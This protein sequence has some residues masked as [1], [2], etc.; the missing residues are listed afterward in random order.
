M[1]T[2]KEAS[3]TFV[4]VPAGT[5][6]ARAIQCLSLGT[7]TDQ[8]GQFLPSF[9]VLLAWE[10]P[11][12]VVIA[13]DKTERPMV[14]SKEYTLSLGKKSNLRRD[15]EGWRGR[16]F[17]KEEL[18]GFQVENVLD[19]PCMLNI[20]HKT[21]ASGNTYAV[22][23][24]ISPL[25]KGVVCKPRVHDLLHFE[26]EDGKSCPAWEKIPE[27]IRK[28]IEACEEWIHPLVGEQPAIATQT[29][30]DGDSVPF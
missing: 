4:P 1:P 23:S 28:K 11:D 16:E 10:I 21:S 13:Q 20:I 12:E 24:G 25:P 30:D 9:K 3:K 14:T 17:T 26:I 8:R 22:I 29:P 7:Q 6:I 5:H 27:F 19:A 2:A 15:L 18:G